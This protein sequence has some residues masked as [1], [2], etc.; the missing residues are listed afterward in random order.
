MPQAETAMVIKPTALVIGIGPV[1]RHVIR[2]LVESNATSHIRVV[3]STPPSLQFLSKNCADA[4]AQCEFLQ[5][6]LSSATSLDKI[7][8]RKMHSV[9]DGNFDWVFNC[10]PGLVKMGQSDFVYEKHVYERSMMFAH[11]AA[12]RHVPVFVHFGSAWELAG[13]GTEE[14]ALLPFSPRTLYSAKLDMDLRNVS[15]L[16]LVL[17]RASATYGPGDF[18]VMC[19]AMAQVFLIFSFQM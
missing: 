15:Q 16:N 1:G 13:D 5:V 12:K 11:E 17:V 10:T 2:V 7:F 9:D 4:I 3:D 6:N 19:I 18:G 14:S 8:S